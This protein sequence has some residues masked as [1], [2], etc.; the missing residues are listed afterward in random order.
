M[1]CN[2]CTKRNQQFPINS[3]SSFRAIF[4]NRVVSLRDWVSSLFILSTLATHFTYSY[5]YVHRTRFGMSLCISN[6]F[7]SSR[8]FVVVLLYQKKNPPRSCPLWRDWF[9]NLFTRVGPRGVRDVHRYRWCSWFLV[10][11][12]GL[13]CAETKERPTRLLLTW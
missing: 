1:E 10:E 4:F 13:V 8:I 11:S 9:I 7:F 3:P 2:L 12:F 6:L 5:L